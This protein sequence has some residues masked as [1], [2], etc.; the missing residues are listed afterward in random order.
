MAA[1][2]TQQANRPGIHP[3]KRERNGRKQRGTVAQL[4]AMAKAREQAEMATVISQPHRNGDSSQLCE[5]HLGRLCLAHG[6]RRE[7]YDAGQRLFSLIWSWRASIGCPMP[8][9]IPRDGLMTAPHDDPGPGKEWERLIN[10]AANAVQSELG[11]GVWLR[12]TAVAVHDEPP[13]AGYEGRIIRGL[14]AVA[15]E[16]GM[17]DGRQSAF[18]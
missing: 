8:L 6:L 2:S 18:R 3:P 9:H 16:Y 12:V 7:I 14:R 1:G 17:M 4:E 13:L 11:P 15:V 5:S 10:R